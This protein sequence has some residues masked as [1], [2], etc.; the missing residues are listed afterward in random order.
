MRDIQDAAD[1]L[2]PVYEETAKR[3]GYVSLEVSPFLRED[4][5][6]TLQGSAAI[7]ARR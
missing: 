7:M 6:G 3:D 2:R 1:A 5:E 4:T